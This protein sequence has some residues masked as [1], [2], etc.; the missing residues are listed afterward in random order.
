MDHESLPELPLAELNPYLSITVL[1]CTGEDPQIAFASLT[2]FLR[3]SAGKR[4]R[5]ASCRV[6]AEVTKLAG[7]A[8]ESLGTLRELGFDSLYGV[9][10][11]VVRSPGWAMAE[12]GIV[13]LH[14]H[15]TLA[16][17]R[18]RLVAVC[19]TITS[20][21]QLRSWVERNA[22]FR[23]FPA[24]VLAGTFHGDGR[25]IWMRGVHRR[26]ATR[27]DGK[28]LTGLRLQD[29]LHPLEDGGFALSAAKIHYVPGNDTAVLRDLLTVSPDK[30]KISWKQ[31][32]E[33]PMFLAATGEALDMLGKELVSEASPALPFGGLAVP[34]TDLARVRFAVDIAVS[35]PDQMRGEADAGA[36][37]IRYAE[38]LAQATMEV[39]GRPDSATTELDVVIG[40]AKATFM[41][42]PVRAHSGFRLEVRHNGPP[43]GAELAQIKDALATGGL[44]TLYYGSGHAFDGRHIH[45]R[46][47]VDAP[48][49]NLQFEDFGGYLVT[50][51]KPAVHGDRA[52]HDAIGI[53]G[54]SS[55]FA[56]VVHRFGV[57][58]LLCDDG[59]GEIA[60]FLHLAD[61]GTLTA[62]HVKAAASDSPTR[63]LAVT[64][65]EQLVSQAEKNVTSLRAETLVNRLAVPRVAAHAA[66]HDGQRIAPA[67][68]VDQ[69]RLRLD[70]DP[71][72]VAIVQPH[73]L[74]ATHEQARAATAAG[75][76][77]RD[78]HC[79]RLLDNLLHST[80]RTI[81]GQCDELVVIGSR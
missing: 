46:S 75:K 62:I 47:L 66:W 61:D 17:R 77:T 10:R 54:D 32:T 9:Y 39:R 31:T 64:G 14:N 27:P 56:W 13:D 25:M 26:R 4:G 45:W 33:F 59:A 21:S 69:L 80:R 2:V 44:L 42:N 12:S 70:S 79:L 76:E 19:T 74:R 73:L 30:S 63:R 3:E 65:F 23:F 15:L 60:D 48:F 71:T 6:R 57:G 35:D 55:L 78:T 11:Q 1:E 81:T 20:E 51:E 72:K 8:I 58:W 52:I 41:L 24:E 34:E 5:A 50:R 67:D 7:D 16:T 38:L 18:N 49:T 40:D 28:A 68:F 53:G 43:M 36:D 37:E 22:E 29:A